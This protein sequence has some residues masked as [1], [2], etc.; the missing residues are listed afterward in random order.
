MSG[1][2]LLRLGFL[3]V[4]PHRIH[5]HFRA[6]LQWLGVAIAPMLIGLSGYRPSLLVDGLPQRD[7]LKGQIFVLI[8]TSPDERFDSFSRENAERHLAILLDAFRDIHPH[9]RVQVQTLPQSAL[10]N[11]LARRNRAGLSPDLVIVLGE[12]AMALQQQKL[13]QPQAYMPGQLAHLD[14]D[15]LNRLRLGDGR[16]FGLPI[17]LLPQVACYNRER[18]PI[19]PTTIKQLLAPA[20]Q[21]RIGLPMQFSELA[22][23]LGSLGALDSVMAITSGQPP[24]ASLKQPVATWLGWLRSPELQQRTVFQASPDGLLDEMGAGRLDW[25]PCR[26]YDFYRLRRQLG[27]ALAVASLPSGPGGQASPFTIERIIAFGIN[28]SP[29]QRRIAKAFVATS[30]DPVSQRALSLRS[31]QELSSWKNLNLAKPSSPILAVMMAS[32]VQSGI[33]RR[34]NQ[35]IANANMRTNGQMQNILNR[36]IYGEIETSRAT[37]ILIEMLRPVSP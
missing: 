27:S 26:S 4:N 20:S 36:F 37:N 12:T 16:Y 9:A 14:Q 7:A 11:V 29:N 1:P 24:T 30:I 15:S 32:N 19:P 23:S 22:W 5:P 28:S 21:V 35:K 2:V 6:S 10:I 17:G 13:I 33:N 18:I 31:Q 3:A 34:L 25:M 8:G